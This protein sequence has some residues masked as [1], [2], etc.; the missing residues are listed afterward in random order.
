MNIIDNIPPIVN[1][2]LNEVKIVMES[3]S[4]LSGVNEPVSICIA[5]GDGEQL[6]QCQIKSLVDFF[7]C[8]DIN[9]SITAYTR[10]EEYIIEPISS[11]YVYLGNYTPIYTKRSISNF[12]ESIIK[13]TVE[14]PNLSSFLKYISNSRTFDDNQ[15]FSL[16]NHVV[17]A[18]SRHVGVIIDARILTL[19]KRLVPIELLLEAYRAGLYPF[20]WDFTERS[21]YCLNPHH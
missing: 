8:I 14:N 20:G 4:F 15:L 17:S 10:L 19:S 7:Y 16:H 21:L 5:C 2:Y 3:K 11:A 18:I 6:Y 9:N 1:E 13:S 12:C